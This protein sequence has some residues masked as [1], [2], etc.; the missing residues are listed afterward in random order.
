MARIVIADAGPLIAFA[1]IDALC[2]LQNLFSEISVAESVKGE[3]MRKPGIDSQRIETAIDEGLLVIIPP[4]A[5][6]EP[7]SP[8]LG[9][10]ESDSI[11]YA[12]ESPDESL[13]IVDDRLARRIALKQGINIVGTVRILDLAEQRGLIKNAEQCIAEMAAIGY[14]VSVE[15]LTQ[16]RSQ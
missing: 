6:T 12:L 8:G 7:L 10:G 11:R 16:I 4:G 15:L 13:L 14:R 5:I 1:S 2:V 3:C 9:A